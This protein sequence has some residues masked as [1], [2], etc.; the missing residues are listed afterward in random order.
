M[1]KKANTATI[2]VVLLNASLAIAQT[3]ATKKP[4]EGVWKVDL[5]QSK[6]TS[7]AP[8]KSG[9]LTLLCQIH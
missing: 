9:T 5:K 7:D 6:F 4:L 8:P 3:N 2:L 1:L